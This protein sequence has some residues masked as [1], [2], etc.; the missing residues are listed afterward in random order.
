MLWNVAVAMDLSRESA[1]WA[2]LCLGTEVDA[3]G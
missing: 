1:P 2:S 3:D